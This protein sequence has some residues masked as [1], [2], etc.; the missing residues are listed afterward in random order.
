[1]EPDI[2]S[3]A[4]SYVLARIAVMCAFGYFIFRIVARR[5]TAAVSNVNTAGCAT[6]VHAVPEVEKRRLSPSF[7][8]QNDPD[9]IAYEG[10]NSQIVRGRFTW[11]R[12]E[13]PI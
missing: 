2:T 4:A 13:F 8:R 9:R 1:M 7:R 6:R 10:A 11:G 5:R 3:Y 12:A